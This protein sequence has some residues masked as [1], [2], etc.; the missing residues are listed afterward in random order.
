[1]DV[2]ERNG[3]VITQWLAGTA[4]FSFTGTSFLN[5]TEETVEWVNSWVLQSIE[6]SIEIN[7]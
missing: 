1:M 5:M 6:S 2:V 3:R 7:N 4:D